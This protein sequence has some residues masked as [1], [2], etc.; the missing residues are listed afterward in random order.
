MTKEAF[1]ELWNLNYPEAVQISYLFKHC[2]SDRWFRIHSLPESKRYP[3]NEDEWE[4][5]LS[6]QNE[7]IT[8]LLG[9]E[10]NVLLVT[11]DYD[12]TDGKAVH[13]TQGEDVFKRYIFKKLDNI[14][15][16]TINAQE[17]EEV[18]LYRPVFAEI[19]WSPKVHDQLLRE[20]AADNVRAFFVS[21]DKNVIVAPYDG[22]V[23]FI[24]KD[25]LT[26]DFYKNKY[27]HWLS[28]REDGL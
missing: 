14:Y 2:Y 19:I 13:T 3:E 18:D 28:W 15:L 27:Q 25:V 7:I 1:N 24:M 5:I 6:R 10:T 12:W 9:L 8:D 21:F 20:I 16:H 22:G 26:K 4:I 23:D 11:G 17:F